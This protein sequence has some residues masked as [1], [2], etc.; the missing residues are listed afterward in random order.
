MEEK[1]RRGFE[2]PLDIVEEILVKVP[3]KSLVRLKAVS[4][5]WRGTIESESFVEKHKRYQK[6]LQAKIVTVKKIHIDR[7]TVRS[8]LEILSFVPTNGIVETCP[9]RIFR[10]RFTCSVIAEPCDGLLCIHKSC[11]RITLVNPAT[12]SL[13]RLP[14]PTPTVAEG[15]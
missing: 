14:D 6:S 3:V 5:E 1:K 10:W 15:T 12:N 13:R 4:R 2:I 8:S 11:R 7:R 9:Y